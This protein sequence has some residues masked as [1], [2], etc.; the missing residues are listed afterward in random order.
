[1]LLFR[2]AKVCGGTLEADGFAAA[3][4]LCAGAIPTIRLTAS[5][6]ID[7]IFEGRS[8]MEKEC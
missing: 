3:G 4:A 2:R 8:Y 6:T 7:K 5:A 1:M